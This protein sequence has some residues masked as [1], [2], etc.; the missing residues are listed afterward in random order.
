MFID[1]RKAFDAMDRERCLEILEMHG[2]GPNMLRLIRN[3]WDAAINVCRAKSNY[4][5][6]FQAGRGVT[7]GGPLSAKL[8]NI[9][10]D[11]VVRE[12]MRLIQETLDL[13]GRGEEEQEALLETLFAIFYV[14]DGYIASRDP[15]FLQQAM[16]ILVATFKRVGLETNTK[17]TQ[18]MVCTPGKIW[19][20]LPTDLYR[21]MRDRMGG[22]QRGDDW[23]ARA[24]VCQKCDKTMQARSLRQHLTDVHD[25]YQQIVVDEELLDERAG[26]QYRA[27]TERG[28]KGREGRILC[29]LLGCPGVL[30]QTLSGPAP[31]GYRVHAVGG[32]TIPMLQTMQHAMQPG[33]PETRHNK[34]VRGRVGAADAA[35][36]GDRFSTSTTKAVLR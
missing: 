27:T 31:E 29:P 3:F 12:W 1:L 22:G 32:G 23:E 21:L 34:N 9:L 10:V 11:A 4:G 2:A 5:R 17:K 7:Q 13:G 36:G 8:F 33:L 20:Q 26:V 28:R 30:G 16:D 24:V 6:P 14:D 19:I 15:V 35:G 18:A 25:I